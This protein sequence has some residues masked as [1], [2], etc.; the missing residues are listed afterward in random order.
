ML[1]GRR[2]PVEAPAPPSGRAERLGQ[3]GGGPGGAVVG[4]H[5]DPLHRAVAR[6]GPA[7]EHHRT[8]IEE[9]VAGVEVGDPGRDHQRAGPHP[10]ERLAGGAVRVV[11]PVADAL[12]VALERLL[13]QGDPRQPLD[14]GHAVP[15]GH[16]QAQ[17]EAVLGQQRRAVHLVGQ[18]GVALQHLRQ[19][20]RA[21]EGLPHA[22]LQ[23]VVEPAEQ[24][25]H[26]LGPDPGLVQEPA[27]RRSGPLGGSDRAGQPGL[28]H[29]TGLEQRPPVAGALEGHRQ[30]HPLARAEV[31][32][33]QGERSVDRAAHLQP[34]RVRLDG[35]DV[36]VD[37][38]VVQPD[39]GDRVLERLQRQRV[40]S[41]GEAQLGRGDVG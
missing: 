14:V 6:P 34:E 29:G 36:V 19:R 4:R 22:A 15:A 38:Q 11:E 39:R 13:Q 21:L 2:V 41:P 24:R 3:L 25:L 12:L 23:S 1:A 18:Q 26:G 17:R 16:H 30:A 10:A 37:Q 9:P 28:A 20:Q 32:Q 40:V 7:L 33:R 35:G 27:K 5:L 8:G 31:V